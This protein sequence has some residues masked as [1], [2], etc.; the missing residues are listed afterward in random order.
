MKIHVTGS[1]GF[2]GSELCRELERRSINFS[3]SS[4]YSGQQNKRENYVVADIGPNTDWRN[5]LHDTDVVVHLAARAHVI[6]EHLSDPLSEYRKVNCEGTLNLARQAAELNVRRFV[7]LSSIGVNGSGTD[8]IPFSESST[9]APHSNYAIA[10]W[11]AEKGLK[12]IS[13]ETRMEI[14]IVRPPLVYGPRV[15]GNF[16]RLLNIIESNI[17]LP[18]SGVRNRRSYIS[19]ANLV[20]FVILCSIS[21]KAANQLFLVSDGEDLSTPKLILFLARSMGKSPK[22]VYFPVFLVRFLAWVFGRKGACQ[23]ICGSL[24]IDIS[25][26]CTLLEWVPPTNVSESLRITVGSDVKNE[27]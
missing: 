12:K 1:T 2:I 20:D 13:S 4:R 10:K 3:C 21:T 22:L 23:Q 16:R 15:K 14:V 7:Y 27:Q 18:L 9:P 25:K 26:A 11:E 6:K 24:Q 8:D 19:L 5:I 17:P